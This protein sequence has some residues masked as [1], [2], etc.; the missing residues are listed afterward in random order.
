MGVTTTYQTVIEEIG[1]PLDDARS[2][3]DYR[4]HWKDKGGRLVPFIS[5]HYWTPGVVLELAAA[6]HSSTYPLR[7][8][9]KEAIGRCGR[10][11]GNIWPGQ[12]LIH[13]WWRATGVVPTWDDW[14]EALNGP[15]WGSWE[16]DKQREKGRKEG[17]RPDFIEEAIR[18][19]AAYVW[20]SFIREQR[21]LAILDRAGVPVRYHP[22][23]DTHYKM[24]GW[25]PGHAITIHK[26]DERHRAENG[27]KKQ[28]PRLPPGWVEH[29]VVFDP[30]DGGIFVWHPS[31]ADTRRLIRELGYGEA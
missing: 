14:W 7:G 20:Q 2:A 4:A 6:E 23:A 13:G 28:P 22:F 17:W 11:D 12:F 8:I 27:G 24:D 10:L 26:R 25:V 31:E 21:L 30:Q 3:A 18:A 19:R 5:D 9:S 29:P 1:V 16:W 15:L